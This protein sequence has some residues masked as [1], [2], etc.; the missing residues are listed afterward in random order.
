MLHGRHAAVLVDDADLQVLDLPAEGVAEDDELH[1]RHEQRH[2]D[3]RRAPPEAPQLAFDDG[4]GALH[5]ATGWRTM[6]RRSLIGCS[7]RA[8]R[9][10]WPVKWTKTSSSDVLCTASDLMVTPALAA[11]VISAMVVAGHCR[12]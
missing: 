7:C 11:A 1:Q 5:I 10:W 8:S 9:S 6:L 12:T 3:E 2:D 4:P